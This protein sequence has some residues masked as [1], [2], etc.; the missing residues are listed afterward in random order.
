MLRYLLNLQASVRG[1]HK[2]TVKNNTYKL[3]KETIPSVRG[4]KQLK[5]N[6]YYG[7]SNKVYCI[8]FIL[9]TSINKSY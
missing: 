4:I 7:H 6:N 1:I 2:T 5:D 3:Q 8:Y 9:H